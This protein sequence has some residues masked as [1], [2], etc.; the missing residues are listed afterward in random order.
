LPEES[1]ID[2]EYWAKNNL[3]LR[4]VGNVLE[5]SRTPQEFEAYLNEDDGINNLDLNGDGYVDYISVDEYGGPN[6]YERGLSIYTRFGDGRQ[7]IGN[8]VFYRDDNNYPGARILVT[9]SDNIYGDNYYYEANW[10]DKTLAIA[11]LLF[12]PRR[13]YYVSP[14][15]YDNYPPGY[16]AYDVVDTPYYR[17]RLETLYPQPLLVYAAAPAI[18]SQIKIKSPNNGLHLGQIKARLAKPTK[19]QADFLKSHP[20]KVERAKID[21]P[22]KGGNPPGLQKQAKEDRKVEAEKG[23]PSKPDKGEKPK[24]E[25]SMSGKNDRGGD[26]GQKPNQ[27]EKGK[28]KKPE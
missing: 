28:G 2:D 8:V 5:R 26:K 23:N 6:D 1:P 18:L 11:S 20:V 3:D 24:G 14:Y 17:T 15:Y 12:T 13:E 10:L 7:E 19:E 25:P 4:R 16:V 22:G 9:G 27:S 21:K